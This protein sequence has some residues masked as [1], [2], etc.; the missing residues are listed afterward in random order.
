MEHVIC[1]V[2][3]RNTY[4]VFVGKSEGKDRLEDLSVGGRIILKYIFEK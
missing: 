2:E 3:K 1:M 4:R